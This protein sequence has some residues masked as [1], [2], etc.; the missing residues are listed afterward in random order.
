MECL[1]IISA[2]LIEV[3]WI[4]TTEKLTAAELGSFLLCFLKKD[5][6]STIII[7]EVNFMAS[8]N[9]VANWFL[10]KES[11]TPKKLHKLCYYSKAWSLA[12][13]NKQFFPERF[14]AWIHGP[15]STLLY[16]RFHDQ[17]W[18]PI[19][20]FADVLSDFTPEEIELLDAIWNTYGKYSGDQLEIITHNEEPW[21]K[22][23]SGLPDF[24]PSSKYISDED[25]RSYYLN[26]YQKEQNV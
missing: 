10:A 2:N 23:R 7:S 9:D 18:E 13:Y 20:Q 3:N 26:E 1:K 22:T 15:A 16:S 5:L 24:A 12:L 25:M 4:E 6:Q 8:I 11:M 19:P 14:Q 17:G 21:Q